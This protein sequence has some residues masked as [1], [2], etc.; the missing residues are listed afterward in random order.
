MPQ[1]QANLVAGLSECNS[2]MI[3]VEDA[4][5]KIVTERDQ[6]L[7]VTV[8]ATCVLNTHVGTSIDY[9]VRKNPRPAAGAFGPDRVYRIQFNPLW[10][11]DQVKGDTSFVT[12]SILG[13][14]DIT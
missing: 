10:P 5:K 11:N 7:Y 3:S 9:E 2:A 1:Q 12:A 13:A 4:V 6:T 8:T 14:L